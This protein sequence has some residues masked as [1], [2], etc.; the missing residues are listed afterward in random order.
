M[1]FVNQCSGCKQA[2]TE[3]LYTYRNIL[4]VDWDPETKRIEFILED[5]PDGKI[6]S[7]ECNASCIDIPKVQ[8]NV[9]WAFFWCNECYEEYRSILQGAS[10][11][12]PLPAAYVAEA[13]RDG[14]DD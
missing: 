4:I 9:I 2:G 14:L 13:F 11:Q 12:T 6:Y 5:D 8:G 10:P 1:K 7:E 3:G